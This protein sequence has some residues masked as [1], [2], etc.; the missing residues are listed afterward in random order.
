MAAPIV[1][2]KAA[3]FAAKNWRYLLIGA[4]VIIFTIVMIPVAVLNILIP[5]ADEE[6]VQSYIVVAQKAGLNPGDLIIFDMV[7]YENNFE[8]AN[9]EETAL[10][11]ML[12]TYSKYE[13]TK[14]CT[15]YVGYGMNKRC[16]EEVSASKK[17][18]FTK[19]L[20]SKTQIMSALRGA[21][22]PS[23]GTF[24]N[25]LDQMN[26]STQAGFHTFSISSKSLQE[27]MHEE[28]FT[29]EQIE[30]AEQLIESGVLSEMF[31]QLSQI[32][33]GGAGLFEYHPFLKIYQSAEKQY[34]V[35][36]FMLAAMHYQETKYSKSKLESSAHAIGPMQF[37]SSTWAGWRYDSDGDGRVDNGI[38]YKD[39]SIIAKGGGYGVDANN[40]KIA[41]PYSPD[42]SIHA[43]GKYLQALGYKKDNETS[44]KN[45]FKN[46]NGSGSAAVKYSLEVYS[47]GLMIKQY[48][49][50]GGNLGNGEWAWPSV[51]TRVTSGF[52]SRDCAGCSKFHK[53]IDVGAINRGVPGDAILAAKG[54]TVI[55]A[56]YSSTAGNYVVIDHGGGFK[57]R[58]LHLTE[59]K[60]SAG[61]I[62]SRGQTIGTMGTTGSSTGVH[63]HFE[64][65]QNGNAIDPM[66]FYRK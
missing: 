62:V 66:N 58:Y 9:P 56:Q 41:D 15:K 3:L 32:G 26:K 57:T 2:A 40:D 47:N 28:R 37:L 43:S 11:F 54:G 31:P 27:V 18:V 13:A 64:I 44:M 52:G 51:A 29:K 23:N 10:K 19:T 46:Y 35:D 24:D 42:D 7:R 14:E 53:G 33:G 8:K 16:V 4:V 25:I 60:T 45:A 20:S 49:E 17:L 38:N 21:G 12:V 65:L 55:I 6:Q 48:H 5:G 50:N 30:H 59:F 63:L 34:G 61:Q 36:W 1:V 22:Y 39:L